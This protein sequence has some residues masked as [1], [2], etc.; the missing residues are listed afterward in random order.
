MKLRWTRLAAQDFEGAYD[1]IAGDNVEAARAV[2][3]RIDAAVKKLRQYPLI[4]RPGL[5]SGT[6][7]WVVDRTRYLLV[8]MVEPDVL[9]ILRVWHMSQE[10]PAPTGQD[11]GGYSAA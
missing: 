6:R 7:E 1:F 11:E 2:V 5:E 9:T 8:Y 3:A 4:G 10:R